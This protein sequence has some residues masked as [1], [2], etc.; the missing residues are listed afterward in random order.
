MRHHP[1]L[2]QSLRFP[3]GE[4]LEREAPF[5]KP[6]ARNGYHLITFGWTVGELVRRTAGQSL[7]A[8][9]R[10][11]LAQPTQAECWIGLP[12]NA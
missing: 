8:Y 9:F 10:E 12:E 2:H 11:A 5:W 6:G 1:L 3:F 7:G 4:R